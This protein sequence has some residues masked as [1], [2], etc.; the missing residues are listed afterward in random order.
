MDYDY[1]FNLVE[2]SGK[3]VSSIAIENGVKPSTLFVAIRRNKNKAQG[4]TGD[5]KIRKR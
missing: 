2:I 4:L 5:G 3:S 1:L